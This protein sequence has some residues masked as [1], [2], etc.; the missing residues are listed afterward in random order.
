M[1]WLVL[2]QVVFTN[3]TAKAWLCSDDAGMVTRRARL[4]D[5]VE[6]ADRF[7]SQA[8][9]SKANMDGAIAVLRMQDG[10]SRTIGED[11]LEGTMASWPNSRSL[12]GMH[13]R[14]IT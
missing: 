4:N 8:M 9:I 3:G 5:P 7:R 10:S 12:I 14:Q 2:L 11:E 13:V 1:L 6:V